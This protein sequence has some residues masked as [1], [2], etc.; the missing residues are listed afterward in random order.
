V[1]VTC[2]SEALGRAWSIAN[3]FVK[4]KSLSP[5]PARM[6]VKLTAT[7]A[8]ITLEASDHDAGTAVRVEATAEV[9]EPGVAVAT[10][11]TVAEILAAVPPGPVTLTG[12]GDSLAIAWGRSGEATVAAHPAD[13][14]PAIRGLAIPA[15]ITLDA[16]DLITAI[17]RV[18]AVAR[19]EMSQSYAINGVL[20]E[21]T[22]DTFALV[23]LDGVRFV[24]QEVAARSETTSIDL[25]G[26]VIPAAALTL[27]GGLIGPGSGPVELGFDAHTA[28]LAVGGLRASASLEAR[29]FAPYR[30]ARKFE[31]SG[32]A[33]VL[34]PDLARALALCRALAAKE[35]RKVILEVRD[36]LLT[37]ASPGT[38][39]GRG[40]SSIPID[41]D[42][43]DLDLAYSGEFLAEGLPRSDD[44]ITLVFHGPDAPLD[45]L[46]AGYQHRTFPMLTS[47]VGPGAGTASPAATQEALA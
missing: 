4:S 24:R 22:A 13:L 15:Q 33:R 26:P 46:A 39:K 27:L 30:R 14:F 12:D 43:D 41:Y 47:P 19:A 1:Q 11:A 21:W 16:A 45:Y 31:E 32:R 28:C 38:E 23:A 5:A 7:A 18:S 3:R 34:G 29:R 9:A 20:A 17:R 44:P 36:G 6:S 37:V 10:A 40:R 8:G 25:P 2:D 42:G 35:T